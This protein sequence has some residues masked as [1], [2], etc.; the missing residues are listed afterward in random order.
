MD[1][2]FSAA[3]GSKMGGMAQAEV[4]RK[5]G[6]SRTTAS[7]WN[8]QLGAGGLERLRRL[9]PGTSPHALRIPLHGGTACQEP[10]K[11]NPGRK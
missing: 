9:R 11:A 6:V 1:R 7:D 4:G 10:P 3:R 5:V 2:N 8:E